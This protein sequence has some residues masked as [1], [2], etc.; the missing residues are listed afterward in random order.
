MEGIL[1]Y[2]G[3]VSAR[4]PGEDVFLIQ[5]FGDSRAELRPERLILSDLDLQVM[6]GGARGQIPNETVIHAEVY[7]SRADVRA[8]VHMHPEMATLFTLVRETPI[9]PVK[10]HAARWAGGVPVHPEPGHIKTREEGRSLARTLGEAHAVLLRAHGAVLVAEDVTNLL[11]DAI[12]F[13]ENARAQ[14]LASA[15][16]EVVALSPEELAVLRGKSN[17]SQHAAKLWEYYLQLGVRSGVVPTP[18]AERL[19]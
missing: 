8:V 17:R 11:A 3:H 9:L 12:H 14:H 15:L 7:R 5:P 10:M 6:E 2:S 19:G 16:G 13:E 1:G 18:W 4:L